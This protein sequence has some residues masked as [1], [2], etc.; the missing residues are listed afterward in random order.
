MCIDGF[1]WEG[2]LAREGGD[3]G[4]SVPLESLVSVRT[5]GSP[6]GGLPWCSTLALLRPRSS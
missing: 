6:K 5:I 2:H 1:V 4:E 3:K